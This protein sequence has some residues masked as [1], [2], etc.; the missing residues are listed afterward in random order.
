MGLTAMSLMHVV[1]ALEWRDLRVGIFS[2]ATL[3]NGRFVVL[4]LAAIGLAFLVTTVD[5]LQ[6]IFGTVTL[7][8]DQWR[9]CL[10]AVLAYLVVAEVSKLALR[11]WAPA[12]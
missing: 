3:A 10:L 4:M 9:A 8:G 11:R 12:E 5:G 1:A 6:R 2:R 7:D